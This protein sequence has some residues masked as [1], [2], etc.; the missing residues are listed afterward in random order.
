MGN[1]DYR[2]VRCVALDAF[3]TIAKLTA[4]RRPYAFLRDELASRGANV[5]DFPVR[6]MTTKLTLSGLCLSYGIELP[7]SKMNEVEDR[8]FEDLSCLALSP[9]AAD[10]IGE[11][12]GRGFS[13]VIASN[14]GLPYGVV[15]ERMLSSHGLDLMPLSA[16]SSLSK[17]FSYEVGQIKP[18]QEFYANI[19]GALALPS[20]SFLMLGDKAEEDQAAPRIRGWQ[21]KDPVDRFDNA[22]WVWEEL[23]S[24]LPRSLS[25]P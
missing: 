15:L 20:S 23:L 6:A 2:K 9:G 24:Q 3:G 5:D 21:A 17:A 8:L 12:V 14:L 7:L 22:P 10:A 1:V 16:R 11:M 4:P 19:D 18:A 13:V 25:V